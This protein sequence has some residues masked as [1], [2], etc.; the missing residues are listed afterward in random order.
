MHIAR[1]GGHK[2]EQKILPADADGYIQGLTLSLAE[3]DSQYLPKAPPGGKYVRKF[4]FLKGKGK[5][6]A[7]GINRRPNDTALDPPR[8]VSRAQVETG[9]IRGGTKPNLHVPYFN[10]NM[11]PTVSAEP[12]CPLAIPVHEVKAEIV[13]PRLDMRETTPADF[14]LA[15]P[16]P[17]RGV[18][19]TIGAPR[20]KL[21]DLRD[22][23][24]TIVP[25]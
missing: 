15:D 14:A 3:Q 8:Q 19:T 2:S 5:A 21:V 24:D 10:K 6:K 4:P 16:T 20:Y 9:E 11:G 22:V 12:K 13:T 7:S 18:F 17:H 25:C 1:R 23:S